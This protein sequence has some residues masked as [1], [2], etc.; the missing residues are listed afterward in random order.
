MNL[1]G[2]PQQLNPSKA[3]WVVAYLLSPG[4][5]FICLWKA[6]AVSVVECVSGVLVGLLAHIGLVTV[7]GGTNGD[8]LQIFIILLLGVSLFAIVMWQ[9]VAGLRVSLWTPEAMKQWRLAGRFF[10]GL[11]AIGLVVGIL[12]FHLQQRHSA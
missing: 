2:Q 1:H 9:F 3:S 8:P 6:K 5:A 12:L 7:L 10:G 4:L 11:L